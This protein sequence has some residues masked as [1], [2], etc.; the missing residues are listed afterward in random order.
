MS[1]RV[2]YQDRTVALTE[3]TLVLRGFTK[4]LGR[5]R[6]IQLD[7]IE[8]FRL[9]PQSDFPNGQLPK[10]GV[11]DRGVW[12]TRDPRRWRRQAAIE[13]KFTNG[14]EVGFSPAHVQRFRELL[15]HHGVK[16]A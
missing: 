14:D 5:A 3:E 16:E 1:T 4:V 15:I 6:R 7:Q 9:R 2:L 8:S 13:V 12:Y 11:D 10:W